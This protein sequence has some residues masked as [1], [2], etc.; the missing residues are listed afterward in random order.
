MDDLGYP[1][2]SGLERFSGFAEE[3]SSSGASGASAVGGIRFGGF[4]SG[5]SGGCECCSSKENFTNCGGCDIPDSNLTVTWHNGVTG[6]GSAPLV[7]N[8]I[9]S[10]K[11]ACSGGGFNQRI[12]SVGCNSGAVEFRVTSFISGTCPDGITVFCSTFGGTLTR[13]SLTCGSGFLMEVSVNDHSC[14][15]LFENGYTGFTISR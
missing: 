4:K 13:T 3:S 11:S 9:N 7:F 14:P 5:A 2:I 15:D 10:W 8:G 1:G 12:F 6:D